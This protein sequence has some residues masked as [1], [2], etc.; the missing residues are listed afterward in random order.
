MTYFNNKPN[1]RYI[2]ACSGCERFAT[3]VL[4]VLHAFLNR[5]T[6][7]CQAQCYIPPVL[8]TNSVAVIRNSNLLTWCP[9][10]NR[11]ICGWECHSS[12]TQAVGVSQVQQFPVHLPCKL[13]SASSQGKSHVTYPSNVNIRTPAASGFKPSIHGPMGNYRPSM[14][15]RSISIRFL[16][17][18][19]FNYFRHRVERTC[20][21][22]RPCSDASNRQQK[23]AV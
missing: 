9:R 20:P 22:G 7:C 5:P 23:H 10:L 2:A 17:F 15:H 21:H 4:E 13:A 8:Y 11:K 6:V 3:K 19:M 14:G 16:T 1:P 12:E 18:D